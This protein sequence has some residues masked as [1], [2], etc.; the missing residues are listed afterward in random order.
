[1]TSL[2]F[3]DALSYFSDF[4]ARV[5]VVDVDAYA[6]KKPSLDIY[7]VLAQRVKSHVSYTRPIINFIDLHQLK[8]V[9]R[10]VKQF[11]IFKYQ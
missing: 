11:R 7:N 4:S 5:F 3:Y 6:G 10:P 1:M 9:Q 2:L 8:N